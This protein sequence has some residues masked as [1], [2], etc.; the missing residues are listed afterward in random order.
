MTVIVEGKLSFEFAVEW[1]AVQWDTSDF[2]KRRGHIGK[3]VDIISARLTTTPG[4]LAIIEIKDYPPNAAAPV[5][6]PVALAE[7]CVAKVRDTLAQ[8]VFSP[9]LVGRPAET[10]VDDLCRAYG[11]TEHHLAVIVCVEDA[12]TPPIDMLVLQAELEDRFRWLPTIAVVAA[13]IGDISSTVQGL[14]VSRVP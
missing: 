14:T 11:S 7:T 12:N 4:T 2:R 3:A 5:P 6:A 1:S 10:E 9:P 13:T 8:I